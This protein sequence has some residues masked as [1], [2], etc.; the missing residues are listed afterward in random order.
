M[1]EIILFIVGFIK[2]V[3]FKELFEG[4]GDWIEEKIDN[5]YR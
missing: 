3:L 1:F 5:L 4:L 2:E